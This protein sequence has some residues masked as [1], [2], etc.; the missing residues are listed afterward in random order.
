MTHRW[1]AGSIE[2]LEGAYAPE[3][4]LFSYSS[5]LAG[6][7]FTNDFEHPAVMRYTI[8][9]LLGLQEANRA[10]HAGPAA[11]L[12]PAKLQTFL[13]RQLGA[14]DNW[15][16]RGLLLVL[17]SR[18]GRKTEASN[19]LRDISG[20][21]DGQNFARVDLQSIA[22]MLW[23]VAAAAR[24][25]LDNAEQTA[26]K[27]FKVLHSR[28]VDKDSLLARHSLQRYR[29]DLVSF[30]GTAY[31]LRALY[32]YGT[33]VNDEYVLSLFDQA[34]A[35]VMSLQGPKGEWPW[36]I[37]VGR[38]D[39]VDPYPV[40]SVHQ[41]SMAMLFLVPALDRGLPG[42]AEAI[43]NSCLWVGGRN[44]LNADLV[45]D[46]P[47]LI[48]RSIQRVESAPRARRYLRSLW[49]RGDPWAPVAREKVE[50]NRECRSYHIGWILFIWATREE[51]LSRSLEALRS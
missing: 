51:L 29:K 24:S 2:F 8:N 32:E 25:G 46:D 17:L 4:G 34:V 47:F 10:G 6:D 38:G 28:Y 42:A 15:A 30:G 1:I 20:F 45:N 36:M 39:I 43:S 26:D 37:S 12:Y 44:E 48:C 23:G 18:E 5:R 22:W 40:F 41:D 35:R 50:I 16:D 9:S 14:V 11:E 21:V 7:S 49:R 33:L 13:D 19:L 3:S 27:L 31:Y